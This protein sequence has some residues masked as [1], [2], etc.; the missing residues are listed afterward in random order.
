VKRRVRCSGIVALVW[1]LASASWV[2]GAD[3]SSLTPT[4]Q[5]A[6]QSLPPD[7]QAKA[8]QQLNQSGGASAPKPGAGSLLTGDSVQTPQSATQSLN[9]QFIEGIDG[10]G[11][12][13]TADTK[14]K[15]PKPVKLKRYSHTV[16]A[17]A[18]PS[19][20]SSTTNAVGADYP[21]KAGDKL[22]LS[23][24]G[25]P[26]KEVPLALNNKG[27]VF[28]E[29]G[30][31]VSLSGHT[32][33]SAQQKIKR[34]LTKSMVG[35]QLGTTHLALRLEELSPIKVFVLGEVQVPGGYV[36][37]GNTNIFAALYHAKGPSAIGSVR[38][39]RVNR[40]GSSF[41]VDLYDFLLHGKRPG[42]HIL[43]DGDIVFLPKAQ[44]LVGVQG[45]V[46]RPAL[47]ELTAKEG[48][49]ELLEYAGGLNASAANHSATLT[50]YFEDGRKDVLT[51]PAPKE[52]LPKSAQNFMLLHGDIVQIYESSEPFRQFFTVQG[53]V[54]YPGM[55]EFKPGVKLWDA[56]MAAGGITQETYM[57]WAQIF[58]PDTAGQ[59]EVFRV[60]VMPDAGPELQPRDSVVLYNAPSMRIQM[61]VQVAGAVKNPD[62]YAYF[63]NMTVGDVLLFSGGFAPGALPSE[64]RIERLQ[65]NSKNISMIA[66]DCS[67]GKPGLSEK[68]RPLD[69]VVVSF[70]PEFVGQ[71]LVTLQGAFKYTGAFAIATPGETLR[72]FIDRVG[73]LEP[74]AY[75]KGGRFAR[76]RE[77]TGQRYYVNVDMEKALSGACCTDLALRAGDSIF[78][79]EVQVSVQ[80]YGEVVHPSDV[81]FKKNKG[82]WYYINNAGGL[83]RTSDEDRIVIEYANGERSTL[84]EAPRDPDPGS[85]IFVPSKPEPEPIKWT[86]VAS[87]TAQ[88]MGALATT[89]LAI[90]SIM[91]LE[92]N[93]N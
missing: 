50:R 16:F 33:A 38:Q 35:L 18:L 71:Q 78:I 11:K 83:L 23:I 74:T 47:Y 43:K 4:Q 53:E 64:V 70:N 32:L 21:L 45:A 6:L 31:W 68:L 49:R 37:H 69:R 5:A 62:N 81:L 73:I 60:E 34:V 58:R 59:R 25:G 19:A 66:L 63:D 30:G 57:E 29:N 61:L 67:P 48:I 39:V 20:F 52:F 92:K 72:E 9:A 65:E 26:E 24:W 36:F 84:E 79:P 10:Q 22:I 51:L 41:T 46:G 85:R 87:A 90:V 80:V 56:V 27:A 7:Q 77:G 28:L 13:D 17:N 55:Y 44:K 1:F 54:M 89:L 15:Q 86:E 88:I 42:K 12:P 82:P 14:S 8:L 3:L 93:S 76:L 40:G 2:V 75:L 91:S